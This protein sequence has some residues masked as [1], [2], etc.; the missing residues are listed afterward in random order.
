MKKV[1]LCISILVLPLSA[2]AQVSTFCTGNMLSPNAANQPAAYYVGDTMFL[3]VANVPGFQPVLP[4]DFTH[5]RNNVVTQLQSGI[6][7]SY[8]LLDTGIQTLVGFSIANNMQHYCSLGA[9]VHSDLSASITSISGALVNASSISFVGSATGGAGG[10][11]YLWEF[12]DGETDSGQSTTHRYNDAGTYAVSLVVT[13]Q[14]GRSRSASQSITINV[15][16]NVPGHP[17]NLRQE[18]ISC[19]SSTTT[20]LFDWNST[21]SQPSNRYEFQFKP[22]NSSNWGFLY[23]GTQPSRTLSS[24]LQNFNYEWR[25]R[26]CSSSS[27]SSCGPYSDRR[28]TTL[29]CQGGGVLF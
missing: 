23:S 13:D 9:T 6:A 4:A 15:N 10:N 1:L 2:F 22:R 24:L 28:F 12:G 17:S 25:V 7:G 26:G 11:T 5:R 8:T 21:G 29:N 16:T 20:Y 19:G 27:A 14:F 18:S 3:Q